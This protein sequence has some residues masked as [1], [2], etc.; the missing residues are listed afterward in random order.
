MCVL[1]YLHR[2]LTRI[3]GQISLFT[4]LTQLWIIATFLTLFLF[5]AHS[6]FTWKIAILLWTWQVFLQACLTFNHKVQQRKLVCQNHV[7]RLNIVECFPLGIPAG[8]IK[9]Q[10]V[11]V[12]AVSS[13]GF[14]LGQRLFI[15]FHDSVPNLQLFY[16]NSLPPSHILQ[17]CCKQI[18][19]I[20]KA[21]E[22][23]FSQRKVAIKGSSKQKSDVF[24]AFFKIF[25]ENVKI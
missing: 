3:F 5:W 12:E 2:H 4:N 18:S 15:G 7:I 6:V 8:P 14:F 1:V 10:S 23:E 11:K 25:N 20:E 21:R 13:F 17:Q 24:Y 22:P 16:W 9:P 19:L